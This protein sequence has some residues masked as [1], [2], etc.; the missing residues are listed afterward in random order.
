[1]VFVA[2]VMSQLVYLYIILNLA[3]DPFPKVSSG[4]IFCFAGIKLLLRLDVDLLNPRHGCRK[5]RTIAVPKEPISRTLQKGWRESLSA[6]LPK[7]DGAHSW[8]LFN[9]LK[10]KIRHLQ[11]L[12]KPAHPARSQ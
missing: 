9:M 6:Y 2:T 1:M 11:G 7:L 4:S 12:I 8:A 10:I 3:T 5:T